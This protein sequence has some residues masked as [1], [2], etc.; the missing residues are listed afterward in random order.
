MDVGRITFGPRQSPEE[1]A[2]LRQLSDTY[3][4]TAI[5]GLAGR[6]STAHACNCIG[7]QPG[8]TKCPCRLRSEAEQASKMV[9]DGVVINGV[10]YDLVPRRK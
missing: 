2:R 9:R 10:E 7:P 1:A 4:H 5:A 3:R 6:A 8:E